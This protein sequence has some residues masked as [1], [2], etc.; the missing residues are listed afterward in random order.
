MPEGERDQG[1]ASALQ[2]QSFLV[3][4]IIP[5]VVVGRYAEAAA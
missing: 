4:Q 1:R 2:C 5:F 3:K